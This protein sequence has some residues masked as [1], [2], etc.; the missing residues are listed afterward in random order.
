MLQSKIKHLVIVGPSGV[1][2]GTLINKIFDIF[3]DMFGYSVSHTTRNARPGEREGNN[4]YYVSK[5]E[6]QNMK[7]NNEFI[8]SNT[9]NN[10]MY[11]TSLTELNR[12]SEMNKICIIEIDVNGANNLYESELATNFFAILPSD[13]TVLRQRLLKRNTESEAV[14]DKRLKTA[15]KEIESINNSSIFNYKFVNEDVSKTIEDIK[16]ALIELYPHLNKI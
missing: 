5:E 1:G 11:G 2:K 14:I 9:Y 8:E 7:N 6:F 12:Q 10:E 3:P 13:I 16:Q 15:E 4:Y